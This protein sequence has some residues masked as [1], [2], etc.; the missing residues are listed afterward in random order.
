M[1]NY[2]SIES[3]SIGPLLGEI[4]MAKVKRTPKGPPRRERV[5]NTNT[6]T[7]SVLTMSVFWYLSNSESAVSVNNINT[8]DTTGNHHTNNKD[9]FAHNI[10]VQKTHTQQKP[11]TQS[12]R[13][14]ITSPT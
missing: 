14:I 5:N 13:A 6:D 4:Y 1:K 2:F 10:N 9:T 3:K 11:F 8:G 7:V 12:N